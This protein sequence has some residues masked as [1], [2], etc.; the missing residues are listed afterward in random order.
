[1]ILERNYPQAITNLVKSIEMSHELSHKQFVSTGAGL[2]AFAIG[3]RE[4]PDPV[5]ATLQAAQLWGIKDGMMDVIGSGSWL[6]E[7]SVAQ[8][9]RRQILARVDEAHWRPSWE[10][11]RV[12]TEVQVI[13]LCRGL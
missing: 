3:L 11:G 10:A 1:M 8:T 13:E 6:E 12:L 7:W 5:S 4:E 9:M 2:L